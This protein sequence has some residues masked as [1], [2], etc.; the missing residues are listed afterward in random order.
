M[1]KQDGKDIPMN[2]SKDRPYNGQTRWKKYTNELI[3]GQ[4]IQWP[5]KMEKIYQWTNQRTDNAM[6]KQDGKVDKQWFTKYSVHQK[7]NI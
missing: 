5:N 2:K 7:L 3:K 1:A 6:A 4:T